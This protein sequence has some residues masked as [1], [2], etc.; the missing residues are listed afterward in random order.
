[1]QIFFSIILLA[2]PTKDK[3]SKLDPTKAILR[4][5]VLDTSL[6]KGTWPILGSLQ[7]FKKEDWPMPQYIAREKGFENA[8]LETYKES[9]PAERI[10]SKKVPFDYP[11]D[12]DEEGS[13]FGPYRSSQIESI[14]ASRLS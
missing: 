7:Q 12:G 13:L 11:A 10:L 4:P 2:L 6:Q 14:V 8:W 3:W 1:M 9:C 5:R